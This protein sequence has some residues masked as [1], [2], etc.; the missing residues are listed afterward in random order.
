MI[1]VPAVLLIL[2][3]SASSISMAG[4]KPTSAGDVESRGE[5]STK[6]SRPGETLTFWITISNRTAKSI[7]GVT[8]AI[9]DAPGYG[10]PSFR[11]TAGANIKAPECPNTSSPAG[12]L[13]ASG[14]RPGQSTV[15]QGYLE[16]LHSH[17]AQ[18]LEAV[19]SWTEWTEKTG[20]VSQVVVTLGQN[21]VE[22]DW[23]LRLKRLYQLL[24]DF[25]LPVLLALITVAI[26]FW[27]KRKERERKKDD[28]QRE[29]A[30]EDADQLR[31]WQAE[32]WR[33]MLPI[34]H[35]M[36]TRY[37]TKIW[38]SIQNAL[39]DHN[40]SLGAEL[41][42]QEREDFEH[43][44]FYN[45]M[46]LG[47]QMRG[48][49]DAVGGFFFKDRV[50]EKL[51]VECWNSYLREFYGPSTA[52]PRKNYRQSI[53]ACSPMGNDQREFL[54]ILETES[55]VTPL[56]Q[57][58]R[59]SWLHFRE[60]HRKDGV[61]AIELLGALAAVLDYEM[62]RPYEHW[63][64]RAEKL[65]LSDSVKAGLLKM[66]AEIQKDGEAHFEEQAQRYIDQGTTSV[67]PNLA[68][69]TLVQEQKT[70]GAHPTE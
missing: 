2:T 61:E 42:L 13:I 46:L 49:L 26:G 63:Y 60:R 55:L 11:T 28:E 37:Y 62:N 65:I 3:T 9:L 39:D 56:A 59:Q 43:E 22:S 16:A 12:F 32:T 21:T 27:D 25:A 45:L 1:W 6:N 44:A 17:V 8:T 58:V 38:Q 18:R 66:A 31:S 40:K 64:Q 41:T 47:R 35:R 57:I 50:G 52:V 23:D 68:T 53:E 7:C 54:K 14:L 69:G 10:S 33:L 34:S 19:V 15:V 24:K 48:M 30:R 20:V 51:A 70:Q 5:I 29:K 4:E 67:T 36:A